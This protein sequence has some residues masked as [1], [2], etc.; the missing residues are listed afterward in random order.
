[1]LLAAEVVV[2]ETSDDADASATMPTMLQQDGDILYGSPELRAERL[3][4]FAALGVDIVKVRVRWRDIAPTRPSGNPADPNTYGASWEPYQAIIDGA[5]ARGMGVFFQLGGTA[6]EWATAGKGPVDRPSP[7]AFQNFVQAVGTRFPQVGIW[8]VWNEPNLVSWLAPQV[9]GGVPQSPRIYRNLM[10]AAQAGL[11]ASGNGGDEI[12][13]GELL[14]F[15]RS[16]REANKKIRPAAFLRE[17][18]CVDR[19]YRAF[20]G[21]TAKKRGCTGFKALPGTGLAYHPYTLAGGPNV[22]MPHPDDASIRYLGRITDVLDKLS[23]KKR[24]RQSRMPLWITEFGFQTNPPDPYASPIK[25]VPGFMG[26]SEFIAF[27]NRRVASYSQYPLIDDK[28]R[29]SGFQSGLRFS[30]GRKKGGVF[31]A[32]RHPFWARRSGSRVELFGG[33]RRA[34]GGTVSLESKVGKKG[35]WKAMK[36]VALNERGYFNKGFRMSSPSKRYFRFKGDGVTS[37]VAMASTR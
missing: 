34:T 16:N 6:P 9:K 1:M 30:S 3:D 32:F 22:R 29:E 10:N 21:S 17:L 31:D 24:L 23:A 26:Q 37:R 5:N 20:R 11:E 36:S 8:S 14:P 27:K 18:A 25:K 13:L 33:I 7:T 15:A 12:L 35:K 19:K 2:L 4:D 28:G